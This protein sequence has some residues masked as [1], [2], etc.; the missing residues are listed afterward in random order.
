MGAKSN[1]ASPVCVQYFTLLYRSV[2][3]IRGKLPSLFQF[4]YFDPHIPKSR[5]SPISPTKVITEDK[6]K[7][8]G[9]EQIGRLSGRHHQDR[10]EPAPRILAPFFKLT[11][12][13]S[14]EGKRYRDIGLY[15]LFSTPGF[16]YYILKP[17]LKLTQ[18]WQWLN[19]HE[20]TND[21]V[22]S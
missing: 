17:P 14:F 6:M 1:F 19:W 8:K 2:E 9:L 7:M 15:F 21:N 20:V 16:S 18:L 12:S 13:S 22:N 3:Q 11:L 5:W 4:S 10:R